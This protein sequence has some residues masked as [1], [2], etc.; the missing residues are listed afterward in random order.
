MCVTLAPTPN[1]ASVSSSKFERVRF[2]DDLRL[3]RIEEPDVGQAVRP[4][5]VDGRRRFVFTHRDAARRYLV[6]IDMRSNA[7]RGGL[8]GRVVRNLVVLEFVVL[9]LVLVLVFFFVVVVC[10]RPDLLAPVRLL[11]R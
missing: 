1:D 8:A 7:G 3:R 11:G 2:V 5:R 6:V 9:V 10:R 4:L